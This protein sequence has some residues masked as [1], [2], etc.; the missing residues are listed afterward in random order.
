LGTKPGKAFRIQ[1]VR[2]L[3][4][5]FPMNLELEPN[6][7]LYYVEMLHF[8]RAASG[9]FGPLPLVEGYNMLRSKAC[10]MS[11]RGSRFTVHGKKRFVV[12]GF[13]A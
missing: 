8:W 11:E 2:N 3:I 13:R 4:I 7:P 12:L 10:P 1:E 9:N 6:C 5:V